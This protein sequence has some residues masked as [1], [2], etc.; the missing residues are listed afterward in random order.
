MS[1]SVSGIQLH[2]LISAAHIHSVAVLFVSA[3]RCI[4]L[5]HFLAAYYFVAIDLTHEVTIDCL[6]SYQEKRENQQML[7]NIFQNS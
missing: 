6:H 5:I 1:Y 4:R 3:F 2:K 7:G